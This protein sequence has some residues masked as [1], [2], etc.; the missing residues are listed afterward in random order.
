MEL[1]FKN[2]LLT[3]D[4]KKVISRTVDEK[5]IDLLILLSK[6]ADGVFFG[7][8][9]YQSYINKIM[10][11]SDEVERIDI[12]INELDSKT[13][14]DLMNI[15]REYELE[16]NNTTQK[17][18]L[19]QELKVALNNKKIS[20]N[21]DKTN[22]YKASDRNYYNTYEHTINSIVEDLND[23]QYRELNV[24]RKSSLKALTDELGVVQDKLKEVH[25]WF[26]A[27]SIPATLLNDYLKELEK[28]DKLIKDNQEKYA[29]IPDTSDP[30]SKV[31]EMST[32]L[33][34]INY[35]RNK[36]QMLLKSI[37]TQKENILSVYKP[38]IDF[39]D[40]KATIYNK[41]R[42][43]KANIEDAMID[44]RVTDIEKYMV[45]F[46]E[47]FYELVSK[48]FEL[49]NYLDDNEVIISFEKKRDLNQDLV[50]GNHDLVQ[51]AGFTNDGEQVYSESSNQEDV[52]SSM[53][54]A[55]T[56]YVNKNSVTLPDDSLKPD[57]KSEEEKTNEPVSQ[58]IS[59]ESEENEQLST[60]VSEETKPIDAEE[61]SSDVNYSTIDV[62]ALGVEPQV[63]TVWEPTD[64][65]DSEKEISKTN[66][67]ST[68]E[69]T[70]ET[71][72][73]S[74]MVPV[75]ATPE[76]TQMPGTVYSVSEVKDTNPDTLASAK[77]KAKDIASITLGGEGRVK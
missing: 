42:F 26:D 58:E 4:E 68:E 70:S 66:V 56:D 63:D 47:F 14:T 3:E 77:A 76:L 67:S 27:V 45:A 2:D 74:E 35:Y 59:N 52:K 33:G 5:I 20:L 34:N 29:L 8:Q 43:V 39:V 51:Y 19:I 6:K 60:D 40:L 48:Q 21:T 38:V 23:E 54:E 50:K 16:V 31:S 25:K 49:E 69:G 15:A 24:T 71:I 22:L 7:E 1:I 12:L 17:E 73:E 57:E 36:K 11:L 55:V 75:E 46:N 65:V 72:T 61:Q 18:A 13:I 28:T 9:K 62:A 53:I 41:L 10:A 44:T 64:H 30:N 32:V 37:A